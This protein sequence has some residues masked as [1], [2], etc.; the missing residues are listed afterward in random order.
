MDI[1]YCLAFRNKLFRLPK[2]YV[3]EGKTI[4]ID[5]LL[6]I[7]ASAYILV[8]ADVCIRRKRYGN[9]FIASGKLIYASSG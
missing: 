6:Y 3:S 4:A 2:R 5:N 9:I 8:S 1:G 7:S